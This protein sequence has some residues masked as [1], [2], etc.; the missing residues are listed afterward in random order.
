MISD[1]EK[2]SIGYLWSVIVTWVNIGTNKVR[3]ATLP[4]YEPFVRVAQMNYADWMRKM[5]GWLRLI[6]LG[7]MEDFE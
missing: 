6:C 4:K 2:Y 5:F 7:E 1:R 3:L